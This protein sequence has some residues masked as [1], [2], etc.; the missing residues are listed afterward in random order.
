MV[1]SIIVKMSY[2]Q[3]QQ[4]KERIFRHSSKRKREVAPANRVELVE[5]DPYKCDLYG[6]FGFYIVT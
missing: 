1:K 5:V 4:F 6:D 3:K 2:E